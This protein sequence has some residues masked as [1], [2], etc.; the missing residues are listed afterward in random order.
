MVSAAQDENLA[1][2][3]AKVSA[4]QRMKQKKAQSIFFCE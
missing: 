4:A 2:A 3:T 1:F